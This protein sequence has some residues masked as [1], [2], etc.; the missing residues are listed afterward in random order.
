MQVNDKI[1]RAPA[2]ITVSEV[3]KKLAEKEIELQE[4]A[5]ARRLRLKEVS[6]PIRL[7][8][9]F[10]LPLKASSAYD[11]NFPDNLACTQVVV[12]MTSRATLRT[13]FHSYSEAYSCILFYKLV[14][15]QNSK[16]NYIISDKGID[17][18]LEMVR[19]ATYRSHSGT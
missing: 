16:A 6:N 15:F 17:C 18:R 4:P 8:F 13:F 2:N 9:T 3:D 10:S 11:D 19:H 12:L 7:S 1:V 5:E 14:L